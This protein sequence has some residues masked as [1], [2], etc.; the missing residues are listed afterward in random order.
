MAATNSKPIIER[1]ALA[2]FV[3]EGFDAATTKQIAAEAGVS[4]G[5]IYRHFP[6]KDALA[7]KLFIEIHRKLTDVVNAAAAAQI[8]IDAQAEAVVKAYCAAADEDWLLYAFHLLSLHRFLHMWQQHGD[9][10]VTAIE[11]IIANAM[12]RGEIPKR[13]PQVVAGMA[14]GV[15]TQVAQH[16]AHTRLKGPL[17]RYAPDFV[18]GVRAVL[19]AG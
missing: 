12:Q 11:R 18:L 5:A 1:A 8:G 10:P 16:V 9:D 17:S 13:D 4:E 15:V 2:L 7:G 3:R 14:L 6:S 19:K